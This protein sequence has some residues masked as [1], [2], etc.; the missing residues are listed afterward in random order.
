LFSLV[1]SSLT[2]ARK[3]AVKHLDAPRDHHGVL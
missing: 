1:R 2:D 3:N